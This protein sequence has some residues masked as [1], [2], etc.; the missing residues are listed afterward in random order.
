MNFGF[1]IIM[2][3]AVNID[4]P[5]LANLVREVAEIAELQI[6]GCD[7]S[8]ISRNVRSSVSQLVS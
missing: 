5:N 6:F 3:F 2:D 7:S 8:S 1:E 4:K